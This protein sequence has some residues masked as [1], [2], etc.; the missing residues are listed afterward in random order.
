MAGVLT[1][2]HSEVLTPQ[3]EYAAAERANA[4][5][6]AEVIADRLHPNQPIKSDPCHSF[7]FAGE[8]S[9]REKFLK[10]SSKTGLIRSVPSCVRT[11]E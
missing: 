10:I 11:K 3:F 9:Q 6:R 5:R 1:P 7:V 2:Q 8:I 4:A